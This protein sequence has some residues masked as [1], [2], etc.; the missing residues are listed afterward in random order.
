MDNGVHSDI[1]QVNSLRHKAMHKATHKVDKKLKTHSLLVANADDSSVQK[2]EKCFLTHKKSGKG[3]TW[4]DLP[5]QMVGE[6]EEECCIVYAALTAQD[7]YR[8]QTRRGMGRE[9]SGIT[10][11]GR[12]VMGLHYPVR[13]SIC[14]LCCNA[15]NDY[16]FNVYE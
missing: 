15:H 13:F 4:Q 11:G 7:Q 3:F 6:G 2:S 8:E 1:F 5:D 14:K 12:R 10:R 16:A 9:F